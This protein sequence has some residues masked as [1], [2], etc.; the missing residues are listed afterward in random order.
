VEPVYQ[1]LTTVQIGTTNANGVEVRVIAGE[2]MGVQSPI[3][4]RMPTMYLDFTLQPGAPL[5]QPVPESY[6]AFVYTLEGKGIFGSESS[7]PVSAHTTANEAL[8]NGS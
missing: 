1:K 5:S 6:T 3:F 2:S 7:K 4:T 8:C